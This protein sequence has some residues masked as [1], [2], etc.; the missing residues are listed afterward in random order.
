M[1]DTSRPKPKIH[2][3]TS[4]LPKRPKTT[5]ILQVV[6]LK[7]DYSHSGISVCSFPSFGV[8]D[9][10]NYRNK[11]KHLKIN[12]YPGRNQ[13]ENIETFPREST[14]GYAPETVATV[15]SVGS[16]WVRD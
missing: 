15:N 8:K 7:S 10:Q 1:S 9:D 12:K 2:S 4:L 11:H 13:E 16:D 14:P 6:D 3:I 5:L